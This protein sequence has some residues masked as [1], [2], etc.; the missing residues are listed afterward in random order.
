MFTTFLRR[1]TCL[2]FV[3][4]IFY[5]A[6]CSKTEEQRITVPIQPS[7]LSAE[8][9]TISDS[10]VQSSEDNQHIHTFL[11]QE[12]DSSSI[13]IHKT[14]NG[15]TRTIDDGSIVLQLCS[16]LCT[17]VRTGDHVP[18]PGSELF[19]LKFFSPDGKVHKTLRILDNTSFT[20]GTAVY[21][22]DTADLSGFIT[23]CWNNQS[24]APPGWGWFCIDATAILFSN[25]AAAVEPMEDELIRKYRDIIVFST[26]MMD[27]YEVDPGEHV[28]LT[29]HGEISAD[30]IDDLQVMAWIPADQAG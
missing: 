15:R 24:S 22:T 11:F 13:K 25:G 7:I 18:E 6:G 21:K 16:A 28:I 30:T 10:S 5:F 29:C 14:E 12:N 2:L 27:Q 9:E 17:G 20:D 19:R 23:Y 26:E 8:I 4:L 3:C 1:I